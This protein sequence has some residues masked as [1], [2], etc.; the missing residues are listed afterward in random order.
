[1]ALLGTRNTS[2][3]TREQ[4]EAIRLL[5]ELR[6]HRTGLS[7]F[8][9][10]LGGRFTSLVLEIR[11]D[12][13]CLLLDELV[14]AHG[15]EAMEPGIKIA[16]E[17][18]LEGL[19][20]SF[21]CEILDIGEDS[22]GYFYRVSLPSV[23]KRRQR[24]EHHRVPAGAR[25][26]IARLCDTEGNLSEGEIADLSAAGI[27]IRVDAGEAERLAGVG[28]AIDCRIALGPD[29]M[30]ELKFDV[31][32]VIDTG[33]TGTRVLAGRLLELTPG[34]E[35]RIGKLVTE[36]ER[37]LMRKRPPAHGAR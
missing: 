35:R 24:R 8:S 19:P 23:V 34:I 14:P 30:L 22:K 37:E 32:R 28:G 1:M 36:L 33:T 20:V 16:A 15:H 7:V 4:S 2:P 3:R 6:Q 26:L 13:S 5:D 11:A 12:E 9:R 25:H 21:E 17:A 27:S 18:R 10:T 31:C 29:D